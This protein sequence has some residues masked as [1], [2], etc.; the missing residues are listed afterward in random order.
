MSDALA[1]PPAARFVAAAASPLRLALR[2]LRRDRMAMLG[3]AVALVALLAALSAPLSCALSGNSPSAWNTSVIDVD[4]TGLPFG[5]FG[6]ISSRHW[7]GVEPKTGRDIFCR[8]MYGLRTSLTFALLATAVSIALG[9][10]LGAV[11]GYVGGWVD[12]LVS[13]LLDVL[14]AFPFLLFVIATTPLIRAGL[15]NVNLGRSNTARLAVLVG[16]VGVFGAPL[17]ARIVRALTLSLREREFVLAA[18]V[19]GAGP[20]RILVKEIAPN[21]ASTL[22]VVTTVAI[23]LNVAAE[24]G[25]SFLGVGVLPSGV[26]LGQLQASAIDY[27]YT[28][29]TFLLVPGSI[30]FLTVLAFTV[31]GDGLR[32]ALDPTSR[33]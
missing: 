25:L 27:V 2:R 28:D 8:T 15:D 13:R 20:A 6:G 26:S 18:K 22:L 29:P 30:L 32:D 23:P 31:L 11:A 7:F 5:R 9:A 24:A 3:G 16:I 33:R 4:G 19:I 21:L 1:R 14:L 10:A 12:R 17:V